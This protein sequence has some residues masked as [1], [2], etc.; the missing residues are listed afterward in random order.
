MDKIKKET[1][2]ISKKIE[3]HFFEESD[4]K[5]KDPLIK[6]ILRNGKILF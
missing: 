5:A 3:L 1:K 6:E 2:R 4:M